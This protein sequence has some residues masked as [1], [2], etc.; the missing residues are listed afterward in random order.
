[1]SEPIPAA[2]HS[3]KNN[4][5]TDPKQQEELTEEERLAEMEKMLAFAHSTPMID[6]WEDITETRGEPSFYLQGTNYSYGFC[7]S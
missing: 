1:M 4:P 2:E 5:Q 7:A 3:V 6:P